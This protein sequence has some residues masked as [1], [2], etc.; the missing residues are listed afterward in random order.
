MICLILIASRL[1]IYEFNYLC[2]SYQQT[3][4]MNYFFKLYQMQPRPYFED[5][6]LADPLL[7]DA[8]GEFGNPSGHSLMAMQFIT[9]LY[10]LYTDRNKKLWE[11]SLFL[12]FTVR[13]IIVF[14]IVGIS[15]SRV[16]AGRHSFDQLI[17]GWSMG[18]WSALFAHYCW[19]PYFY[20]PSTK[21]NANHWKHFRNVFMIACVGFFLIIM[22]FLYVELNNTVPAHW[23]KMVL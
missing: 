14:L 3:V 13:F 9:S 2:I 23:Y 12:R 4:F 17:Q 15:Y 11:K 19:K 5:A 16:Y 20:D 7:P 8:S 18:L 21:K 10:L 22:G 6:D 1:R